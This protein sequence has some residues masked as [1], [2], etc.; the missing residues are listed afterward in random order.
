MKIQSTPAP[1]TK[2]RGNTV[3]TAHLV[4]F[5]VSAA[6][7]LTVLAGFL[8]MV[9]LLGGGI[10]PV[11]YLVA[12]LV[13]T[14]FTVGFITMTKRVRDAGAFYAYIKAGLGDRLGSG[15]ALVAYVGYTLGQI[16]FCAAAGLFASNALQ[17][18]LGMDIP[19]GLSAV[20]IGLVVG[21]L[22]Y[23]QVNI[24]ARVLSVLLMLEIGI[25][26][27]LA[28]AILVQGTPE[29][30]SLEA[31]NPANW[32]LSTLGPLLVLTFIVYIGFEQT[33]IY[34]EETKNSGKSVPRATY[35]AVIALTVIYTFMAWIILMAIGP[36]NLGDVLNGNLPDLVFNV[37]NQ[38]LGS[39]LT[40]AM[41]ILVVTS[42]FAGVLALQNAGA[43][44]MFSMSR[45]R[46]IPAR[47]SHTSPKTGSPT[48]A[49]ITQT[50]IVVAA[51]AVF[52]ILQFDPYTQVIIWT[53][54]PTLIAVLALQIGTSIAVVVYFWRAP[55]GESLWSRLI[56]P[57]A[58]AILLTGVLILI[59]SELSLLTA[60]DTWGN[61]LICVPLIIAFIG[62][63]A[64]STWITNHK[65]SP[66]VESTAQ[67]LDMTGNH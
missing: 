46:L 65:P 38:Y 37:S 52:A 7:P 6:A 56:A 24:G 1:S 9:F 61:F 12:G 31:F 29:G 23:C 11:G 32:T 64:R 33:A 2:L 49:A 44:Y 41:Q 58:S 5:V 40:G 57:A 54:T 67:Q 16:G 4:F 3:S 22:S 39:A 51:I 18:F 62:G 25:L 26:F 55:M 48:V 21:L 15:A 43:R 10:S 34:S 45:T 17:R 36:A 60:L 47:F 8:P 50:I 20:I 27:V 19:W 59:I 53:N 42:F 35:I 30:Y 13:Y 14:L 66:T 28:V 63:V